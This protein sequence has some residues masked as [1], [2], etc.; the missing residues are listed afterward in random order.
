VTGVKHS[1]PCCDL[2]SS[3]GPEQPNLGCFFHEA[4]QKGVFVQA[5]ASPA[6]DASSTERSTRNRPSLW[7][8]SLWAL[9]GLLAFV[10]VFN[11]LLPD[12]G[13][14]LNETS[15]IALG[16]L[17]S[18]VPALLW[19]AIFY[20]V[21]SREPE[22]K[23]LVIAVYLVGLLLAAALFQPVVNGFFTVDGWMYQTWWSQLLGEILV[24]GVLGMGLVYLAVRVML[25][26]NPEFDERLD[27]IIYAMAAGLGIATV[28]NFG[29]VLQHGGVDLGIGSIRMVINALGYASFAGVLGYFIGQAHFEKTPPYY[30]PLGLGLAAVLNGL[31]FFLLDHTGG[32]QF[33]SSG[34]RDLLL[35]TFLA[36]VI[37]AFVGALVRRSNE[38]TLRVSQLSASGDAWV[39]IENKSPIAAQA[40][41]PAS[42]VEATTAP[43][44]ADAGKESA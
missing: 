26:S 34:W 33:G 16:L 3:Q 18:V 41:P 4:H 25:Y 1:G 13:S 19:L 40:A 6:G 21:D 20:R 14:N 31:Y 9:I 2:S 5:T 11:F 15:L 39:P 44:E 27:G 38:E 7:R 36:V 12:L 29:Y 23:Q 17:F 24:I 35:A 22:P 30:L 8:S 42:V 43:A 32:G 10:G 28:I 37:L